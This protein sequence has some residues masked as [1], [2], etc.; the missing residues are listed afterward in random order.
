[1][2]RDVRLLLTAQGIRAFGYG[3]GA[4]LLGAS[5]EARGWSELQAGGLLAGVV[6]GTALM[7]L[8]VGTFVERVGRRR[9]YASLFLGLAVAGVA[10]AYSNS[11]VLLLLVALTGTLSTDVIESGPLT[12]IEQAMLP[13]GLDAR[14]TTRVF[15]VYNAVAALLGSAGAL[16]A[17]APALLRQAWDGAPSEQRFFLVFVV[18]GIAGALL[19]SR[20]S[21]SVEAPRAPGRGAPL[22]ES[23]ANVYRLGALFAVDSFAG[24]FVVQSFIAYWLRLKF[25][26][27]LEALGVL[28]FALGLVQTASFLAAP[29]LAEKF[30]LLNTMVFSHLPSNV[31]LLSVAFV[32]ALP[33][34]VALLLARQALSQMDVPTR[35]AYLAL[36]VQPAERTAAAAYTNTARYATR[37][38][39]PVLAGA[40]QQLAIGLPFMIGGSIKIVYDI[41]LW[42]WFR[43]IPLEPSADGPAQ[44]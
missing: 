2:N 21:G 43:R 42:L 36:L 11:F 22:R 31:L 7:S 3:L 6:A 38:I 16:A 40:S 32:P 4:V 35:Q 8:L 33:V 34:A 26:M 30:G 44:R 25:D 15:G 41:V 14:A 5:L 12:S 24:G 13:S 18:A 39:A 29:R 10:F 23:R 28:F 1:V 17:S 27:S 20:L 19:A 37:P 9:W